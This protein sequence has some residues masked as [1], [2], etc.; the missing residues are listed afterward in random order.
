MGSVNSTPLL[1]APVSLILELTS[2]CNLRCVYCFHFD[3]VTEYCK[4]L[5]TEEWLQFIEELQSLSILE[6][7]LSGGEPFSRPDFMTICRKV[8]ESNIRYTILSN[9]TMI[10]ED[11][12]RELAD[13]GRGKVQVSLDG[14]DEIND[15]GRGKGTFQAAVRGIRNLI[16]YHVPVYPRVTISHHNIGHLEETA[17]FIFNDLGL[18]FFATG[19]AVVNESNSKN[20]FQIELTIDDVAQ[21]IMEHRR[22]MSKYPGK[23]IGAVSV[24]M[25]VW[26]TWRKMLWAEKEN[27]NIRGGGCHATCGGVYTRLGVRPD[28]GIVPCTSFPDKVLGYINRDKLKDVWQSAQFLNE[29]RALRHKPITDYDRCRECRFNRWCVGSCPAVVQQYNDGSRPSCASTM[30]LTDF[31]ER[32]PDFDF[33]LEHI[34]DILK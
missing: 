26:N 16:K 17:D 22:V 23:R 19:G 25:G 20:P 12:A 5:P 31:L 24:P 10:T 27:R 34:G 3:S 28:G 9:G 11:H 13:I 30:C 4:D 29:L 6:V 21:S 18:D 33:D 32:F 15:A 14:I 7:S 8:A 1:Q 2:K